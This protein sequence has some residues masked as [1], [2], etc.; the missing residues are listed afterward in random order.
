[1]SFIYCYKKGWVFRAYVLQRGRY[2]IQH[3]MR[4][5]LATMDECVF[6]H[7]FYF[8]IVPSYA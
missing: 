7:E 8:F 6:P 5:V 4:D 2:T 1:M 3:L